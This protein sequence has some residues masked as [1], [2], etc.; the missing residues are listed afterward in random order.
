MSAQ[1]FAYPLSG[2]TSGTTYYFR[3]VFQ[4]SD[5]GGYSYGAILSFKTTSPSDV[6]MAPR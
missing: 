6:R 1:P 5:N 3:M 4:D 2:L